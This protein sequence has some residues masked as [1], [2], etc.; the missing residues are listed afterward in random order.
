MWAHDPVH[1]AGVPYANPALRTQYQGNVRQNLARPAPQAVRPPAQPQGERFG[2]RELPRNVPPAQ[3]RGVFGGMDNGAAA[4]QHADHGYS[5]MGPARSAPRRVLLPRRVLPAVAAADVPPV[6]DR[7]GRKI[8][9]ARTWMPAVALAAGIALIPGAA[10]T[11]QKTFAN[12][13]GCGA[14]PD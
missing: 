1:R 4:R 6:A 11:G 13:R 14:G 3:N 5:S 10:Q 7:R 12:S 9:A 2:N 8:M